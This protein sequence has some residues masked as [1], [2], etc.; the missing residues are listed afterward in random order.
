ME[1]FLAFTAWQMKQ[2]QPYGLLHLLLLGIGI[3]IAVYAGYKTAKLQEQAHLRLLFFTGLLLLILELYKQAFH[4]YIVND[5]HYDWWIFPFQL[6]SLPMYFCTL[7]PFLHRTRIATLIDS[8]LMDFAL[9][10]GVMALLFPD[11]LMHPY[12]T[13]TAHAFLWHFALIFLGCHIGFSHHGDT[14]LKGYFTMLPV[15]FLCVGIATGFNVLFHS[16]GEINMFY[17]SPY[18]ATTQPFFKALL[19][20]FGSLL[21]N[22][23]YILCMCLGAFLPHTLFHHY[24]QHTF[25]Q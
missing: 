9:L 19:P 2:P 5:A 1:S 10:G 13:L 4:F 25:H 6:C 7:C 18:F 15:F 23:I 21:T 11:G 14:S 3:P 20:L 16:Y 24:R 8:F 17:I 12:V 22:L